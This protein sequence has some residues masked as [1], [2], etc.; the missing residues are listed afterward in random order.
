LYLRNKYLIFIYLFLTTR[1]LYPTFLFLLLKEVAILL[2]FQ[3]LFNINYQI[4]QITNKRTSNKE[5]QKR[6]VI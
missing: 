5:W 2:V 4:K 1:P 3:I 6:K